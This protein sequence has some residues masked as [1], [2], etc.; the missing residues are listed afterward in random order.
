[1]RK[2][3]SKIHWDQWRSKHQVDSKNKNQFPEKSWSKQDQEHPPSS[4]KKRGELEDTLQDQHLIGNPR[5]NISRRLFCSAVY[6]L[7]TTQEV[8]GSIPGRS[9]F[10]LCLFSAKSCKGILASRC[11]HI[12]ET[13]LKI[14]KN[15]V[16]VRKN[17]RD[18]VLSL[19]QYWNSEFTTITLLSC[20]YI[21]LFSFFP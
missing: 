17:I 2:S 9:S 6:L 10:F 14:I 18:A 5:L 20:E 15:Y 8:S 12:L 11:H 7:R 4:S 13:R 1:M 3:Q 16:T 21:M 19:I